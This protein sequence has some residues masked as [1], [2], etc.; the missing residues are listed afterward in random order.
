MFWMLNTIGSPSTGTGSICIWQGNVAQFNESS[1]YLMGAASPLA[2]LCSDDHT[3]YGMNNLSVSWMFLFGHLVWATGFMFLISWRGYWQSWSKAHERN[4]WL[5]WFAGA[6]CCGYVHRPRS[7]VG[8]AHFTV[9]YVPTYA[10]FLSS[11]TAEVRLMRFYWVITVK[12][13]PCPQGICVIS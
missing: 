2:V 6:G 12:K 10:A 8:L 11:S 3:P 7:S 13:I 4:H 9:G 1:T 5:T